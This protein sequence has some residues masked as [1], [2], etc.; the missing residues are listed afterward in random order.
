MESLEKSLYCARLAQ[1]KKAVNIVILELEGVSALADYFIICGGT[2]D[3]HVQAIANHIEISLKKKLSPEIVLKIFNRMTDD[4]ID[5]MGFNHVWSHPSWMVCQVLAVPP[6]A[7]RPSI[8]HDS[9]QRSEDDV[10]HIIVNIIKTNK[11]LQEKIQDNAPSKVIDDWSTVLQYYV[12]TMVDNKIP[13]VA[14]N[15]QRSGRPLKSMD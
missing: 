10:S 13:G 7:V 9:Q 14:P 2:S 11:S 15:S 8:K 3:R 12:A 6:P 4:D 1:D 5:Y